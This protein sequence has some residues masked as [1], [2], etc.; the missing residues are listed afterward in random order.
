M[1]VMLI[2]ELCNIIFRVIAVGAMLGVN[3]AKKAGANR[4]IIRIIIGLVGLSN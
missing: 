4:I 2:I 1:M 3:C